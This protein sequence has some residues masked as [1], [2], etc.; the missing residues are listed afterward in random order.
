MAFGLAWSSRCSSA[1]FAS[2]VAADVVASVKSRRSWAA[3]SRP[4]GSA[5]V[6]SSTV[7]R[8]R[9]A[10]TIRR[11]TLAL[12]EPEPAAVYRLDQP[13]RA[14][15]PAQRGDMHVQDLGRAVPVCIPGVLQDLLPGNDAAGIG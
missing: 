8:A 13:R 2:V 11:V 15:F 12:A 9:T 3:V 6:Q 14:Q 5:T 10:S 7:I 1:T 4:S